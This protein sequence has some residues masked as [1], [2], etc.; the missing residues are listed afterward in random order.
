VDDYK[1]LNRVKVSL[2][3]LRMQIVELMKQGFTE[4]PL[5]DLIFIIKNMGPDN[6]YTVNGNDPRVAKPS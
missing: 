2:P 6:G 5:A 3:E 4:I 1:A